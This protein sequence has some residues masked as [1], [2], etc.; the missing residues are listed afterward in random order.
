MVSSPAFSCSALAMALQ[1]QGNIPTLFHLSCCQMGERHRMLAVEKLQRLL[2]LP[3]AGDSRSQRQKCLASCSFYPDTYYPRS[4]KGDHRGFLWGCCRGQNCWG[5]SQAVLGLQWVRRGISTPCSS[6]L[7]GLPLQI[8]FSLASLDIT[9]G[10]PSIHFPSVKEH[11]E[12]R[13]AREFWLFNYQVTSGI[14]VSSISSPEYSLLFSPEAM[15][16]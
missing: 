4:A 13:S 15:F 6:L 3:W 10:L 5:T 7:R 16:N 8:S 11:K 1:V 9:L 2:C 12:Y 14:S